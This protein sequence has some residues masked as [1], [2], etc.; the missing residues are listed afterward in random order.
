MLTQKTKI[1]KVGLFVP[2]KSEITLDTVEGMVSDE[3]RGSSS[4]GVANFFLRIFLGCTF[5][6]LPERITQRF[7]EAAS[8]FI[9]TGLGS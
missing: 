9:R 5:T 4:P 7:F 1:F 8:E 6:E 3:Q 2:T